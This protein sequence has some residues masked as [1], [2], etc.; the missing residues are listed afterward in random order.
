MEQ[1]YHIAKTNPLFFQFNE[2]DFSSILSCLGGFS[3]KY[4][5]KEVVFLAGEEIN[6]LGLII[7]GSVKILQEDIHAHESIITIVRQGDTFAEVFACANILQ[8]PVTI[9]ALESCEILFLNY[10][11][12]IKSCSNTCLFHQ[13]IIENL[14]K[15]IAQKCLFLNQKV[16]ILSKRTTREKILA[17]LY[18][19]GN[20]AKKIQLHLNREE[21]AHF[22]CVDRSA[23]SAELSKMQKDGIILYHK[24]NF[25]L[26]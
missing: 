23:L 26:L 7:S 1:Y 9:I 14:L 3:K 10:E 12:I 4:K 20:G 2:K 22:I 17:F 25:E 21:M 18:Y 5:K 13:Q 24:N 8:S 11:K 6:H 19:I 16:A 15:V